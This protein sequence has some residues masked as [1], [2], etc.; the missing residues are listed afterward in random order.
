M[1]IFPALLLAVSIHAPGCVAQENPTPPEREDEVLTE[2]VQLTRGF[3]RAGEAYFSADA[4]WVVFQ[5]SL[6]PGEDY[7]MYVASL[8]WEGEKIV[9]MHN[10]VRISPMPSWNSCGAFSPDGESIIF[11]STALKP[12]VHEQAGGYQRERGSYRWQMPT[13]AE[14]FKAEG[15]KR[16]VAAVEP[17]GTVDLAK[18]PLTRN[19][20]YDA[21]CAFSPDGKW[22]VFASKLGP[23]RPAVAGAVGEKGAEL[24]KP[25]G[26]A[27]PDGGRG[28]AEAER[29]KADPSQAANGNVELFVMKADGSKQ[30]RLTSTPGYDGGP[31]FSPDGKRLVYRSDRKGNNLLQVYVADLVVDP[32]SGDITGLAN[33]R[34][35]TGLEPR[36]AQP[37]PDN[38]SPDAT[39]NWAPFWHPD[40][41]H[42]AWATSRHGHAN[43]EVYLM[44][45]DGTRKTR[46]TFKP[47]FDGLPAFSP[48]G[49]WMMWT[50]ARG[51]DKTSQIWVARFAMPKGS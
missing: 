36:P 43:Y 37:T 44:R 30:T 7:Q 22:I 11:S 25:D 41:M 40:G 33:E 4:R 46:I 47:G 16:A 34:Q 5:A 8:K 21:E 35:L 19:D 14:I 51:E 6:K 17:G 45:D 28:G 10:P 38:P 49:K 50:S 20:R 48:D 15:W 32:Q 1:R 18:H 31:F 12:E 9:G 42:I 26:P 23:D 29:V 39:V 2:A 24:V 13:G 3:A 27:K